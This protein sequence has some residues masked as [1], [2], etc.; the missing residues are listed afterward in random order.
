[1][2]LTILSTSDTHGY[3]YPT[4]FRKKNQSLD[5]GLTK[6]ST[7]IKEIEEQADMPVIKI[8]NGDFLQGSPFSYFLAKNPEKGSMADVMNACGFDC[9]VLGNHEFNYGIEYLEETISR[10]DYPIVCANILK[11][12][13]TFLTGHP[14][15]ILERNGLKVAVLGLTTQYIP[16]WEQPATVKDLVFKSAVETAKE[17][18]PKLREEADLVVVSYH[19]GFERD[20][21]TGEPTEVLTGENEGYELLNHVDGID[22]LLTGHQHRVIASNE[23][24]IPV[25]QPGDKGRFI[26]KVDVVFDEEKHIVSTNA[27]LL[28]VEGVKEDETVHEEFVPLLNQVEEWLDKELG[29]VSGDMRITDPMK[30][31]QTSHPY[32]EFIQDVQKDATG[33]GISGTALFDNNGTGF[34][35]T[36]SMR[37]IVTNYIYPNTLAV[38][39]ISGKELRLA[40]ERCASYFDLNDSGELIVSKEFL[41]P[42]VEHYNYDLY[43]GIDY[44]FDVTKQKGE[45]VTQLIYQGKDILDIDQLE[46]VMNQYRAVGGG[47]Y[48]M[49][50]AEKIVKEVTVDMT[51]LISNYL[52]KNPTIQAVQPTNF[53]L[54]Y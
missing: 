29:F 49:F 39:S 34:G 1:M 36:I 50:G 18:I 33:V 26:G 11:K 48:F 19:G 10:L 43:S 16:H 45:R 21:E 40:L 37:D 51:E 38:L 27:E 14:Y 41:E 47:D 24:R 13:G 4:D 28:T 53:T 35:E 9:G 25:T 6:V 32:I 23:T 31:R 8:D 2:K 12:D 30:V 5:F 3:L 42:K 22:V 54:E 17:F 44:T 52:E 20:L 7:K 46:V 15:A